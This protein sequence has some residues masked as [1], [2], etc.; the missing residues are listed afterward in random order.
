M[1]GQFYIDA[2]FDRQFEKLGGQG[3][4]ICLGFNILGQCGRSCLSFAA[5]HNAALY[6][7]A[8]VRH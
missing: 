5:F 2:C 3:V 7:G 6:D 1:I 4:E 8:S